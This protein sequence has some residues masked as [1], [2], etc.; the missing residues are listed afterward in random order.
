MVWR[1]LSFLLISYGFV[2]QAFAASSH[3]ITPFGDL[4]YDAAF[5]HFDYVNPHAPKGGTLTLAYPAAFD[6]L[7][8]FILKGVPAPGLSRLFESLMVSSLDE[9]Q[10][11]YG[12]I[13]ESITLAKDR[14]TADFVIR[15][16]ARWHD[17]TPITAADVVFSLD[18]LKKDGHPQY[19]IL[20]API[21]KAE[22]LSKRKVR[23]HFADPENRELPTL[24][25]SMSILPRHYYQSHPFKQ[26]TLEPPLGSGPYRIAEVDQGRRIVYE[27]VADYWGATLPVNRGR[28][29]FERIVY[30]VYRDE[31]V[32]VEAIKSGRYD[33]REEYIARNWATAYNIPA[34]EKGELVKVKIPH[35]LPSGMQAFIFN[36]RKEKFQDIRVREA[37][38]L[39]MDFQWMNDTLFYGAYE[40]SYSFFQNTPFM[41]LG[42]PGEAEAALLNPLREHIPESVFNQPYRNPVTDGSGYPREHLLKAQALLNEAGYVMRDGVRV[43]AQSGTPLTIEFLMRQ[44]TFAKVVSGMIR[45]LKRLGIA[46]TFRYVDDSQY[47][48]RIDDRDF[49]ITSIWWN[50]GVFFPSNEQISYWHSSQAD[51]P[52]ANNLAGLKNP[53]VDRLLDSLTQA[54]TLEELTAAARALDRTLLHLQ[55]VIP[56][57]HLAAWRVL[58]WDK[59]GRPKQAPKYG[60][61]LDSWW[62][63]EAHR[64]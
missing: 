58:Y 5:Q 10:S 23:F 9:A 21:T 19:R 59:F 61:G 13:A 25:A 53:A 1:S 32:S 28:Y 64:L 12:L 11:F 24:A 14:R 37:I 62:A 45:N 57:W 3:G 47:Q 35:K 51:K 26:T 48:K 29:N 54:Q 55:L 8:P 7:N 63:K 60:L 56:H 31:T 43:H 4:K 34:V 30:D 22:A 52:G 42:L 15:P 44:P 6:T 46:A 20:Y 50:R 40:R 38:G 18:T 27:R 39:T 17:G 2:A 49:D 41:A 16:E 36:L 33:F